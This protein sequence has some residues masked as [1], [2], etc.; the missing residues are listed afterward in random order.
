MEK[1]LDNRL[2]NN[3]LNGEKEA[4]ELLY[5]KYKSKIEYFIYNMIK[6]YEKAE[7]L[8][9]ETFI[10]VMQNK[11]KENINFKYYIYLVARSKVLNYIKVENRRNE[12]TNLYLLR[13]AEETEK[14]ILEIITKN[15]TKKE[16]IEAIEL[17]DEKYKN[18]I[19][20]G[21]IEGLSY[22]EISKILGQ[23]LQN[24]KNLIHRGKK[25]LKRIL[26]KKGFDEMNKIAKVLIIMITATILITGIVYAVNNV[27]ISGKPV[28]EW[29]SVNFSDEYEKYRKEISG[30][31]IQNNETSINLV[32]TTCDEGVT[33]LEFDV[34]LSKDTK[35][36]LKI[37]QPILTEEYLN[38]TDDEDSNAI[39]YVR[40][41]ETKRNIPRIRK[42]VIKERYKEKI[43]EDEI[44]IYFNNKFNEDGS[45]LEN[46][47]VTDRNVIIDGERYYT[48]AMQSIYKISEYEYKLYQMYFL[49]DKELGDKKEF[50]L[51]LKDGVITTRNYQIYDEDRVFHIDGQFDIKLSKEDTL[52]NTKILSTENQEIKHKDQTLKIERIMATP[53]QTVVKVKRV[54]KNVSLARLSRSTDKNYIKLIDY[55]VV[56]D[57][58]EKVNSER[59]ETRRIVTYSNGK[60]EEWY[61]GQIEGGGIPFTNAKMELTEYILIENNKENDK[62]KIIPQE[63]DELAR[64]TTY[65]DIGTF[66]IDMNDEV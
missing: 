32:S 55:K 63:M 60:V 2:Y 42:E 46:Y 13:K 59:F 15:E 51:I 17:L 40:E 24:T 20:L 23:S 11:V 5:N 27:K 29:F 48:I 31:E 22:A 10:Y 36:Y 44:H 18:A 52:K 30:Q 25:Q 14:D 39:E 65:T 37:G 45:V 21:N 58:G 8:T 4:F 61:R 47:G 34:K 12:I 57:K 38:A 64:E 3:Y 62:I 1:D 19:Y 66:E 53:L 54:Y 33:L 7:D 41:E 16:V 9:Q 6:D 26:L 50:T 35:D 28:I 43:V 49:T 56:N